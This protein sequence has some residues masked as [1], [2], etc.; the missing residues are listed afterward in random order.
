VERPIA[1]VS[2]L[3]RSCAT[4]GVLLRQP[5][6]PTPPGLQEHHVA[7]RAPLPLPWLSALGVP[8]RFN[9]DARALISDD[10]CSL[11]PRFSIGGVVMP[12]R[13][14]FTGLG[15][16]TRH[17]STR[18]AACGWCATDDVSLVLCGAVGSGRECCDGGSSVIEGGTERRCDCGGVRMP[19]GT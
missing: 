4:C 7:L 3:P 9:V 10:A 16:R 2:C 17:S 19:L 6:S 1:A 8:R 14:D 13:T 5:D 18:Y 12:S 15:V 11:S